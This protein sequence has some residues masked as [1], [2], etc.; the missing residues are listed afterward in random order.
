M[1]LET[2]DKSIT[3]DILKSLDGITGLDMRKIKVKVEKGFVT[4]TGMVP[5]WTIYFDVEDSVRYTPGVTG[6]NNR[7]S[8]E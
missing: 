2:R 5:T 3:D 4:I 6:V 7:L 1:T 8:V